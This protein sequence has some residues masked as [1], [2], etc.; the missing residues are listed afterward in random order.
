V[1]RKSLLAVAAKPVAG[2]AANM[3][4]KAFKRWKG[5]IAL[6]DKKDM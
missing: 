1:Y 4:V 3:A 2:A 6:P 5:R